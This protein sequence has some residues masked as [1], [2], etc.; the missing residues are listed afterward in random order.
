MR[1]QLLGF[2]AGALAVVPPFL[3]LPFCRRVWQRALIF[4]LW[5]AGLMPFAGG[6][7]TL[8]SPGREV[9]M[10]RQPPDLIIPVVAG[11][12]V[13]SGLLVVGMQVR[14]RRRRVKPPIDT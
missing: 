3:V 12:A 4:G 9:A 5:A 6:V 7:E 1:A 10:G 2:L 8:V 13:A 11:A 14:E